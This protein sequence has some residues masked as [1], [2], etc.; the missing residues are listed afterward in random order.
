VRSLSRRFFY[1]IPSTAADEPHLLTPLQFALDDIYPNPFNQQATIRFTLPRA[2]AV[3][4]E[5]FDVTGRLSATLLERELG[6]G[7]HTL[8]VSGAELASGIYFVRMTADT[9]IKS[10]R[11]L[12][13][14]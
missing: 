2:V 7:A 11:M 1:W 13:I 4:F 12:L 9:F 14:K 8:A 5:L 3:R 6:P 10:K